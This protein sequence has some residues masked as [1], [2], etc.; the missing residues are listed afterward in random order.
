MLLQMKE[1]DAKLYGR[2]YVSR[3]DIGFASYCAGVLLKKGW[4]GQ[5]WE[6]RGSIY[7]QQAAFTSALITAYARPFTT[8][9]GW[10]TFPAKLIPYDA[11]ELTLHN[12]LIPNL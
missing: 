8:S 6:R 5:P 10:P 11:A 12:R 2:L 4:H 7:Q 1:H 9:K 3:E